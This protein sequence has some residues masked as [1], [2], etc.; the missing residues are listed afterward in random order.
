MNGSIK[1]KLIGIYNWLVVWLNFVKLE[2]V[3]VRFEYVLNEFIF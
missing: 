2:V 3:F 1:F